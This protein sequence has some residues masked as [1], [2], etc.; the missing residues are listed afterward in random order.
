MP[1][2]YH[3]I[4]VIFTR[5][6]L[7][8]KQIRTSVFP[9]QPLRFP[10]FP[11]GHTSVMHP[12]AVW[13]LSCPSMSYQVSSLPNGDVEMGKR[14]IGGPHSRSH[15]AILPIL[16]ILPTPP[17]WNKYSTPPSSHHAWTRMKHITD[18]SIR[19]GQ[20]T[21]RHV[22]MFQLKVSDI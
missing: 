5:F 2:P 10:K 13:S 17:Y 15:R 14:E 19:V 3:D 12:T 9:I 7:F 21:P 8:R 16:P 6:H 22:K 18:S 1:P 20:L 11:N 4:P